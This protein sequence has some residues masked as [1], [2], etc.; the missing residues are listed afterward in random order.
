MQKVISINLNGNAYQL[1]ESAFDALRAYLDR[2]EAA[3]EDNPD[4]A[5]ILSDIEQAIA[6]KCGRFLGPQK[7]V[8]LAQEIEEIIKEM[9]PVEAGASGGSSQAGGDAPRSAGPAAKRLYLISEGSMIG[10]VCTG[11]AAYFDLDVTV[12]RIGFAILTLMTGGGGIVLYG[13]MMLFVPPANTSEEHA[14][15]YG[16]PLNAQELV[17]RA[18]RH[19]EKFASKDWRRKWRHKNRQ[20]RREWRRAM[21]EE[22]DWHR[23]HLPN[24]ALAGAMTSIFALVKLTL[25]VLLALGIYSLATTGGLPGWRLPADMPLWVAIVI[26]IVLYNIVTSPLSAA[27]H[28]VYGSSSYPAAA[29][30]VWGGIVWLGV[31]AFLLVLASQH[32][33][34][35]RTFVDNLPSMW[36]DFANAFRAR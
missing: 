20:M 26:L 3:L 7:T 19:Y 18:K 11:L 22:S 12:I 17:D 36:R 15:A 31:L 1:D 23:A 6:D 29:A 28:A 21:R 9:G 5:E 10:G 2:A 14:A 35:I 8:V 16:Q 33:P 4:R 27:R 32:I 24:A 34:E 25:L 30:A 13:A